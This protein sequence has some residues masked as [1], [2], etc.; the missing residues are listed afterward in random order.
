MNDIDPDEAYLEATISSIKG[1]TVVVET[2]SGRV[3][4]EPDMK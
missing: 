1:D 3:R 2:K 4:D